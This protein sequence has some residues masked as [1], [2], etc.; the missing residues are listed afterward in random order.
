[1]LVLAS[2]AFAS[3]MIAA[4]AGPLTAG[5]SPANA[6]INN[7]GQSITLSASVSGGTGPYTIQWYSTPDNVIQRT[8]NSFNS[9]YEGTLLDNMQTGWTS[10][11]LGAKEYTDNAP[12]NFIEGTGSAAIDVNAMVSAGIRKNVNVN[13]NNT[14]NFYFWVYTTNS[15]LLRNNSTGLELDLAN[16]RNY[17]EYFSCSVDGGSLSNGGWEPVVIDKN[18]SCHSVGGAS[19][20]SN[21]MSLQFKV[22]PTNTQTSSPMS[23]FQVNFDNLR[24]NYEGGIPQKAQVLI[25]FDDQWGSVAQKRNAYIG[26]R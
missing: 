23:K 11:T 18:T 10:A 21:I 26:S 4:H 2:L 17:S 8:W 24:Y 3:L 19:W 7:G 20:T 13:L 1:M 22:Y 6:T 15:H 9:S 12:G 25:N 5:I 16:T 14:A